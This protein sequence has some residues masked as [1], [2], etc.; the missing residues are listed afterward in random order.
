MSAIW[1]K[2]ILSFPFVIAPAILIPVLLFDATLSNPS[3][4]YWLPIFG[5]VYF[6][7]QGLMEYVVV[8]VVKAE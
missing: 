8:K 5:T 4:P 7:C 1:T 3:M 2:A 6:T